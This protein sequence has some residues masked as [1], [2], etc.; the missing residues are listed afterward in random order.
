MRIDPEFVLAHPD[1]VTPIA[2]W[3]VALD[4]L[5]LGIVLL[6]QPWVAGAGARRADLEHQLTR[7]A[8][9]LPVGPVYF[10]RV[11][12]AVATLE[13]AGILRGTGTGRARSFTSAPAGLAALVLNLQVLR[14]DPT[15]NGS[16]FELKRA[17]VAMCN[18]VAD[19]LAGLA[20]EVPLDQALDDFFSVA[21][22]LEV[23]GQRVISDEA[24]SS[25]FDVLRL[26]ELQRARVEA[27]LATSERRLES[28]RASLAPLRNIDLA[29]LGA[30]ALDLSQPATLATVRQL[31]TSALP[32]LNLRATVLRYRHYLDYLD[33]L[34]GFY[35]GEL[36]VVRMG[37]LQLVGRR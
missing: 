22:Q 19:R 18:L 4:N 29:A 5:E 7:L 9:E 28:V 35:T 2:P 25:A 15:I 27:L 33:G 14:G 20:G 12:R 1:L 3:A 21:E 16:E 30:G 13:E 34:R 17:L 24:T 23:W 8:H 6:A 10:Q 26:I 36:R 11:N 32:E 37:S 31:A